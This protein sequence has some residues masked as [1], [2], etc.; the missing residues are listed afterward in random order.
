L[1]W[2]R[3]LWMFCL[4]CSFNIE[5]RSEF[6]DD[7]SS[8]P[9]SNIWHFGKDMLKLMKLWLKISSFKCWKYI[10]NL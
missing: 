3:L 8:I 10:C 7:L 2:L 9:S 4:C 1:D 6:V 5:T